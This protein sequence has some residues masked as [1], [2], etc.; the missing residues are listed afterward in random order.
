MSPARASAKSQ[1]GYTIA[2]VLI[3]LMILSMLATIALRNTRADVKH[4]S[5]SL[6]GIRA[7]FV[8]ESAVNWALGELSRPRGD[9]VPY[10]KATHDPT[11]ATPLEKVLEDG[12][13][14]GRRLDTTEVFSPYSGATIKHDADGWIYAETNTAGSSMSGQV[15]ER[16]AFK[17][18]YPDTPVNS[19]RISA[20]GVAG[21]DTMRV[22]FIGNFN[23]GFVPR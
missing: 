22:E 1:A 3:T 13:L 5:R 6:T 11:G 4:A 18:W 9:W 2:V 10:S 12:S 17:V 20:K 16:M 7:N 14:Q 15:P 8:A 19:I 21:K 23:N